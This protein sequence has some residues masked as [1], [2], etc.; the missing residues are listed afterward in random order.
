M[1]WAALLLGC[2]TGA[3]VATAAIAAPEEVIFDGTIT[4]VATQTSTTYV[5]TYAY[6]LS[7]GNLTSSSEPGGLVTTNYTGVL[8]AVITFDGMSY[9]INDTNPL[10]PG[11]LFQSSETQQQPPSVEYIADANSDTGSISNLIEVQGG[12]AEFGFG[13]YEQF[14]DGNRTADYTLTPTS[15]SAAPEPSTWGLL[16]AGVAI[17]G[18]MLRRENRTKEIAFKAALAA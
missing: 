12:K 18:L 8:Q 4:N 15:V 7:Q 3:L 2:A 13:S 16:F 1:R 10:N 11:D 9:T 17:V 5:A 14:S 6:D